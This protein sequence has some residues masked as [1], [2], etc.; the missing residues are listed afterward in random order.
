MIHPEPATTMTP[1]QLTARREALGLSQAQLARALQ[2]SEATISRWES[3][4]RKILMAGVVELALQTLERDHL[5][6]SDSPLPL[7]PRPK[8]PITFTKAEWGEHHE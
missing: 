3:G 4:D 1:Q 2:V 8:T 5:E 7:L 6:R